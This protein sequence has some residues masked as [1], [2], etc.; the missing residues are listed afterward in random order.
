MSRAIAA[1][2][3]PARQADTFDPLSACHPNQR[4]ALADS[5]R[6]QAWKAGRRGGKTHAAVWKLA[7]AA[8]SEPRVR[9]YYVSTSIDRAIDTIWESLVN[10]APRFGGIPNHGRHVVRLPNGSTIHVR[11]AE[12]KKQADRQIRGRPRVKLFFMDELQ[13]WESS[14]LKYTI[15]ACV[16]PSLADVSG[17]VVFAGTG[18]PPRGWWHEAT[19][20]GSHY[21]VHRWVTTDNTCLPPGEAQWLIDEACRTRGVGVEDPSIRREFFAEDCADLTRQIFAV[22]RA[23]NLW[24]ALPADLN[25]FAVGCDVGTVDATA[26]VVWGWRMDRPGLYLA[27]HDEVRG[28]TSSGQMALV[29]TA[30]EWAK[31]RGTV[32]ALTADPAGGGAPLIL[33]L[34]QRYDL[35]IAS[36]EKRDKAAAAVLL[37]NDL[38][39]GTVRVP[40]DRVLIGKLETPEWDPDNVGSALSGRIHWPDVCDAALYGYREAYEYLSREPAPPPTVAE[41]ELAS[42]HAMIDR[43]NRQRARH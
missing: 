16:W 28:L 1:A 29:R 12:N 19:S 2:E 15:D 10:E 8:L 41:R 4:L 9:S 32:Y 36:A 5:A 3:R 35:P 24:H 17:S 34:S 38:R 42:I 7:L 27:W 43:T 11:G 37:R 18:G 39:N 21:S 13:D 20:E 26:A 30:Y 25:C 23:H 14:L 22:D 6:F 40:D 31:A 33:E